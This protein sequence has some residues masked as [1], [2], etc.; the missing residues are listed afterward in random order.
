MF[1]STLLFLE[2]KATSPI[3]PLYSCDIMESAV[4]VYCTWLRRGSLSYVLDTDHDC[5]KD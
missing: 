5:P 3:P 2:V 4:R 1:N